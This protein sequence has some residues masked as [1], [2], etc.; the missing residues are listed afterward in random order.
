M[1]VESRDELSSAISEMLAHDGA[2]LMD[3]RVKKDENCY[4]MVPAGAS[5]AQMIGLPV[6]PKLDQVAELV[7]CS[8]C[9]TKN[10]STHKFCPEC[11]TKV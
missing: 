11:G 5:N 9:G 7:L 4:P 1:I 10:V 8:H 6:R 2:V 3:V